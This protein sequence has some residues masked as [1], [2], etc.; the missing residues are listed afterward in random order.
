MSISQIYGFR[1]GKS[2]ADWKEVEA[3]D[4]GRVYV[5]QDSYSPSTLSNR[6]EEVDPLDTRDLLLVDQTDSNIANGSP[7]N[8]Y[9]DIKHRKRVMVDIVCSS[10][11]DTFATTYAISLQDDGTAPASC[12]YQDISTYLDND[13]SGKDWLLSGV[14]TSTHLMM[15]PIGIT[16][17]Y[18]R[19][20]HTTAGGAGSGDATTRVM[21][22]S[23]V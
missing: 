22:G 11:D 4:N 3:D 12:N 20:T 13:G 5:R 19:I 9:V 23:S 15:L 10:A 7:V 18:L 1:S 14:R 6:T 8:I 2:G 16:G 21:A 17:K